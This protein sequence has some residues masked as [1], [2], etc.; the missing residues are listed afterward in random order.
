[1]TDLQVFLT[2]CNIRTS[3]SANGGAVAAFGNASV[4]INDSSVEFNNVTERGGG[5]HFAED[6]KGHLTHLRLAN[7]T[8]GPLGG[9]LAVLENAKVGDERTCHVCP[10]LCYA[11]YCSMRLYCDCLKHAEVCDHQPPNHTVVYT[12]LC[13][14]GNM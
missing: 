13:N 2:N 9:G 4:A 3:S 5:L 10:L 12:M 7:N 14:A 8:A 11:S 6:S 1:V